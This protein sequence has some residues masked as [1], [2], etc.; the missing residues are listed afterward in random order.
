MPDECPFCHQ[1]RL[2][3][4]KPKRGIYFVKCKTCGATGPRCDRADRAKEHWQEGLPREED[5]STVKETSDTQ[6]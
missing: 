1:T 5:S 2:S 3:I 4:P 6:G